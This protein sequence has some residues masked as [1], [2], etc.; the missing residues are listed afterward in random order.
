V[1]AREEAD[2]VTRALDGLPSYPTYFKYLRQINQEGPRLLGGMPLLKS[3]DPEAVS[4]QIARSVSVL[5][6]RSPHHFAAGHIPGSYGIPLGAPLVTWAGWVIPFGAPLILIAENSAGREEAIRQL[7]RIG[8]DDLRGYLEGGSSA[9]EAAG[10]PIA[11]TPRMPVEELARRME[12]GDV[13]AVIDV[14][15]DAEWQASHIPGALHVEAGRLEAADLP[16]PK[17]H[18][19]VVHCRHAD[20]STVGISLLEQRGYRNLVLLEGGMSAWISAGY[21]VET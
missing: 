1:Q 7:I 15:F 17:D 13:P 20:R 2:F 14:R 16:V 21:P 6:T 12:Q 5:D 10:H 8:Y 4:Q 19:T 11:R 9:W 3:L 18:L